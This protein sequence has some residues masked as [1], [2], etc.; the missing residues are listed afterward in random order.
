MGPKPDKES[1]KVVMSLYYLKI[2]RIPFIGNH[3]G[4]LFI[5]FL[6]NR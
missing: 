4:S 6:L 1:E 2:L 3:I 5:H